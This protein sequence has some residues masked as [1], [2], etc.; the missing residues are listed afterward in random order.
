L[1]VFFDLRL[2]GLVGVGS[3][4][5]ALLAI[6]PLVEAQTVPST[7]N[8][9]PNVSVV[10]QGIVLAQPTTARI[11]LGVEIF[12]ASLATAQSTASQRMAAVMDQLKAAGI[13]EADIR[14]TSYNVNPQ[15]DTRDGNQSVLRGY[16][17]QNLVDVKSTTVGSLG[18]LI[19]AAITAG[20]TRVY[21]IRFEAS[22]MDELKAQARD[23]AM[24]NAR[25]KAEQLARDAGVGLG[26]PLSIDESDTD[27]VTPQRAQVQPLAAAPAAQTPIQPG[28]LQVQTT[29]RVV[30]SLQ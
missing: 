21:G 2:P 24:Q 25:A 11:T 27:G 22:N 23:Q 5:A 1:R 16:Q 29:V 12:D 18:P 4:L 8:P 14:T 7:P 6:T 3:V 10:G 13:P 17:V 28:E 9:T 19:D 20:A 15:Y 26:R 30:W